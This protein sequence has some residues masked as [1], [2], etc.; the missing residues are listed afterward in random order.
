MEITLIL[1]LY[2]GHDE[3]YSLGL[4]CILKLLVKWSSG[5]GV[6]AL[7]HMKMRGADDIYLQLCL[8]VWL[9]HCAETALGSDRQQLLPPSPVYLSL[10]RQQL[11]HF[12]KGEKK[13]SLV[14]TLQNQPSRFL[15]EACHRSKTFS[16]GAA[17][18]SHMRF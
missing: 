11:L 5:V 14:I 7:V 15:V 17:C 13:L 6:A 9:N 8:G 12:R 1:H 18:A 10:P 4:I 16:L 2:L 3:N